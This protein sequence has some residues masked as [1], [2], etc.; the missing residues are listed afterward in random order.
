MG[1]VNKLTVAKIRSLD[2]R[3]RYGDGRGLWLQVSKWGTKSWVF[4]Y[5]IDGRAREMGLGRVKLQENDGGVSLAEAREKRDELHRLL[6]E[7]GD[8]VENRRAERDARRAAT[9]DRITFKEAAGRYIATHEPDWK[10]EK[11]RQQ[12]RNSLAKYAYPTLGSRPVS[13]VDDALIHETLAG[14]WRSKAETAS[15]VK[16]RIIKVREWVKNGMPL[17]APSKT[18]R[19][20]HHAALPWP[21]L[22]GFMKRLRS[23]DSMSARALEFTILT[24]ARTG[25]T[26]GATWDE[27]DL[28]AQTWT[29]PPERM[30]AK[31]PHTVPLSDRAVEILEAL[32]READNPHVFIG[33]SEGKGLSNMAMLECLR[34]LQSNGYTVHGFRSC[35]KDWASERTTYANI[36]SEMALAHTVSD[37]VEAAYRRG[38]LL[39]KRRRMMRDWAAFCES[40]PVPATADVVPIHA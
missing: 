32:P 5:M 19:V 18:R 8:P 26:I 7:G 29:I 35:F 16:Q 23:L 22:P 20:K 6:R 40:E 12:W 36:V 11:H 31:K 21:D 13:A 15:R 30:K 39:E 9:A 4:R 37:K 3:G 2:K 1:A 24:A 33:A 10:N 28:D 25:E 34:G 14:I 38:D 17:P 27:I